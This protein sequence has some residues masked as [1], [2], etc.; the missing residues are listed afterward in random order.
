MPASLGAEQMQF[1][2]NLLVAPRQS[3]A[4]VGTGRNEGGAMSKRVMKENAILAGA[5]PEPA[6]LSI[7][8]LG[9]MG[10]LMRQTGKTC[11]A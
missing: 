5:I 3:P 9:M 4:G 11:V 6:S 8:G 7:L 1:H 2:Y 10:L